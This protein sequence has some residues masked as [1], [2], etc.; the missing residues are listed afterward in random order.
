MIASANLAGIEVKRLL[1]RGVA[2]VCGSILR[3]S[4]GKNIATTASTDFK[5]TLLNKW[6]H[7]DKQTLPI[8]LYVQLSSAG[9]GLGML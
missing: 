1:S 6:Q 2:A 4:S 3:S 9:D 5:T 7:S 8:V